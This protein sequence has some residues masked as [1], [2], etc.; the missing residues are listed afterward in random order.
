MA[1]GFDTICKAAKE[2]SVLNNRYGYS[3][4]IEERANRIIAVAEDLK[5]R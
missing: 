3:R 2:I 4:E 1:D 5:E